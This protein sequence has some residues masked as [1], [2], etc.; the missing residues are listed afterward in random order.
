MDSANTVDAVKLAWQSVLMIRGCPPDS[1]LFSA[2]QTDARISQHLQGCPFCRERLEQADLYSTVEDAAAPK[3]LVEAAEAPAVRPGDIRPV[4]AT[5]G[6]WG[7]RNR[8]YNPPRILVLKLLTDPA[9]AAVVAQIHAESLLQ[10]PGDVDLGTGLGFAESWNTYTLALADLGPLQTIVPGDLTARILA[11]ADAEGPELDPDAILFYFRQLELAVGSFVACRS[12]EKLLAGLE[13]DPTESDPES[14]LTPDNDALRRQVAAEFPELLLPQQA[15]S[16]L[17][18]IGLASFQD[19][20][21]AA[22]DDTK[23]V[24]AKWAALD[25]RNMAIKPADCSI[26]LLERLKNGLVLNGRILPPGTRAKTI[27]AW[28]QGQQH[29]LAADQARLSPDRQY[30][31]I[32]FSGLP[33]PDADKEKISILFIPHGSI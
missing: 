14:E 12:L 17:E 30:F 27:K 31:H 15:A 2:D 4:C 20:A 7:P 16:A 8:Y 23:T 11:S 25:S 32:R 13:A 29:V 33:R 19:A 9:P 22:A 18:L 6:G 26:S 24:E 1:V 3:D 10:G 21:L 28:W 5:L